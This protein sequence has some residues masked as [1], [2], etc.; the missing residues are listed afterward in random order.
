MAAEVDDVPALEGTARTLE[1]PPRG[2]LPQD[3][4]AKVGEKVDA[5]VSGLV[6][7]RRELLPAQLAVGRRALD[8]DLVGDRKH[9][10]VREVPELGLELFAPLLRL[11]LLLL[12]LNDVQIPRGRHEL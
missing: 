10:E 9:G 5:L 8:V 6:H 3:V 1:R 12:H 4:I 7:R 11:L 2:N